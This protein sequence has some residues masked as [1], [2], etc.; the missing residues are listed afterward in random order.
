M[1]TNA[2]EK[3]TNEAE[4]DFLVLLFLKSVSEQ[5][6]ACSLGKIISNA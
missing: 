4:S 2:I 3:P 6:S 1:K 5:L